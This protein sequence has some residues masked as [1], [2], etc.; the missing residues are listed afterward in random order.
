MT[1]PAQR[2]IRLALGVAVG[3][4]LADASIVVLALPEIYRDFDVSVN[5]VIWVLI[6]FNIV[7]A[8]VAVPGAF[9][10][11]RFGPS[12]TTL[13]GLVV[14]AAGSLGCGLSGS[15][16]PLIAARCVQAAGGAV[17][18]TGALELLPAALGSEQRAV[19]V[20]AAAGAAGA[21]IGPAL[22]G[23]LTQLVSWQSIFLVQVPV[24]IAVSL[25]LLAWVRRHPEA[26]APA[27]RAVSRPHLAANIALALVSAALAA[28]LFLLVL[29]IIEGWR[30][31]PIAAAL[32][33]TVLPLAALATGRL[34]GS[35]G[36]PRERAMAGAILLAGGL[37]GLALLPK[38]L[39]VAT[40]VPQILVGAGLAFV[41]SALTHTALEGRSPQAVHGGF[42]LA[43]RHLGVVAGLL[44]M[45][46][47]FTADLVEQRDA[48]EQAGTAALLDAR[49]PALTKIDLATRIADQLTAEKGKVPVI[50]PAFEPLP[51]DPG[52]RDSELALKSDLQD[53][54]DRAATHAF[55]TSFLL[56]AAFGLAALIP[57][58]LARRPEL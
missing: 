20:W 3:M 34:A 46:P 7:L 51:S 37:A 49:L 8:A 55:S 18:V 35:M 16:A 52:E 19:A 38:A 15:L 50:A 26:A 21:A 1:S 28:A 17:A 41:L 30:R 11:R 33:V 44:V 45:T 47:I 31:S 36:T 29:L 39:I 12:R 23:I 58:G 22:G 27:D 4:V 10:A 14:F 24:A 6:A 48:A 53:Q 2:G 57:I 56:A 54:L 42:T 40:F 9:A 13:A 5:A 43:S 25:P 32:A